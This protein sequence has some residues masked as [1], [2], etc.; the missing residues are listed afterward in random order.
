MYFNIKTISAISV[1]MMIIIKA[2]LIVT[3]IAKIIEIVKANYFK[4]FLSH[5]K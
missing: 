2:S 1:M 3:K 5:W 4:L